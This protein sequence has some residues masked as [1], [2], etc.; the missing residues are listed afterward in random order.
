[1]LSKFTESAEVNPIL[2][3]YFVLADLET[4]NEPVSNS[5]ATKVADKYGGHGKG[6]PFTVLLNPKGKLIVNSCANGGD[7]I[8]FP[9]EPA[10]IDWFMAML[11]KGAPNMTDA[12]RQTIEAK[13]R[14]PKQ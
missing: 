1:M 9:S 3:K 14:K 7:N 6:V 8:G 12:E 2:S 10:D 4:G 5:G 13:L 11:K